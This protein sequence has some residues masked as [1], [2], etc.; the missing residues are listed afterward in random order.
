[1][2]N[3]GS[4]IRK[5]EK[6]A[7]KYANLFLILMVALVVLTSFFYHPDPEPS[8]RICGFYNLLGLPCPGCGLTRSFCAFAKGEFVASLYFNPL[9]PF[10]FL[11]FLFFGFAAVL[12]GFGYK[13]LMEKAT[14]LL[15]S[16]L[17]YRLFVSSFFGFGVIRIVYIISKKGF[18]SA[19]EKG[20]I[21]KLWH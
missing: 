6:V 7:S 17:F 8:F 19:V 20:L 5:G 21:F 14:N 4:A 11:G 12:K 3:V 1:M 15:Y 13:R 10:M 9:G 2:E 16:K 18:F